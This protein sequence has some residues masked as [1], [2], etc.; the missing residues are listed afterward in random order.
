VTAGL[1]LKY[2]EDDIEQQSNSRLSS[3]HVS[4]GQSMYE[5]ATTTV[6]RVN[7]RDITN[8][9]TALI[10]KYLSRAVRAINITELCHDILSSHL[11]THPPSAFSNLVDCYN[12]TLYDFSTIML[13]SG[14]KSSALN[15][16]IL[17]MYTQAL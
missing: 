14:L 16:V 3:Q 4:V 12:S 9:L 1:V 7:G 6:V 8:S 17:Y 13:L 15:L 5:D 2:C 11:I 10:T